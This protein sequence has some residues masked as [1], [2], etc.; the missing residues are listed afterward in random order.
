M[1]KSF[2]QMLLAALVITATAGLM[3]A[4]TIEDNP[5]NND[6][7]SKNA[8]PLKV[9]LTFEAIKPNT[10]LTFKLDEAIV[11]SSVE[12]T[13][14]EGH[15]WKPLASIDEAITLANVG[16]K[17]SFRGTNSCYAPSYANN[18]NYDYSNFEISEE[19][20]V[21]GNIMS[22]IDK[23]TFATLTKFNST[24][25][26][27][28]LFSYSPIIPFKDEAHQLLLPATTLT[29]CC[30]MSMF[31][32]CKSMTVAPALP[33]TKMAESCYNCLF[34]GSGLKSAPELPAMDL[35]DY[36]YY[37][38]FWGCQDLP[39]GP[40]VLPA[41]VLA[42]RCYNTMFYNCRALTSA[43]EIAATTMAYQCCVSMFSSCPALKKAPALPATELAGYCYVGMFS[44][45][46]ALEEAPVLPATKLEE[47]CYYRMFE[48][49][50]A[51]KTAPKLPATI[52]AECCYREM[53]GG[54]RG[55]VNAPELPATELTKG[56]YT[57]MFQ[58]CTS[59]IIA[60]EL[61][62]TT[63]AED[64]YFG[65]FNNC[66]ALE[67]VRCHATDISADYCLRGWLSRAGLNAASPT[68][69]VPSTMLTAD[70]ALDVQTPF[71]PA[72]PFTIAPL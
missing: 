58:S 51:L 55:L 41:K 11:P 20:Y 2:V 27:W 10:V 26:F 32:G 34:R 39:A 66:Q 18:I 29:D 4:C 21:Y 22:L 31:S 15:N 63:L 60:P 53:F 62:A 52:L 47:Y 23:H 17:V 36:C 6:I 57:N 69:Y 13:T 7:I 68:L 56:C 38:M 19:C 70:W 44:Y 1:K 9:P 40:K 24:F 72:S 48:G 67:E 5:T 37:G 14:D 64:C 54:C 16:D 42:E 28:M 61:P 3:T 45:C 46:A 65:M 30:Y 35:A 59:L 71:T 25:V 8:P 43:P 33:A 49:C 50:S 12:Y